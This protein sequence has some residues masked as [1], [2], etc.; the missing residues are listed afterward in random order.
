MD[1]YSIRAI[2]RE[3]VP[4]LWDML[5]EIRSLRCVRE[6]KT[7]PSRDVLQTP[8]LAKYVQDWGRKSDR[9]FITF[10]A[11]TPVG[12]AWYR[13]FNADN[14]GYGYV[15][16]RTPELAIAQARTQGF[17]LLPQYRNKG[18]GKS[19]LIHLFEQAKADGYQQIS[20][21]CDP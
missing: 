10:D 20:L 18:L 7:L 15:D 4:F 3:D 9:A 1:F 13:L 14:S 6:G 2:N 12:A 8:D 16:D 19:L 5:Y 11:Q 21:S 17:A